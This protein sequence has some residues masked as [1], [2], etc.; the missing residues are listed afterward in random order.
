MDSVVRVKVAYWGQ[1]LDELQGEAVNQA[2]AA[3]SS[4]PQSTN[5]YGWSRWTATPSR[6]VREEDGILPPLS[7]LVAIEIGY[8]EYF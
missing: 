1:V 7:E 4:S 5:P 8:W 6:E 3:K 2:P